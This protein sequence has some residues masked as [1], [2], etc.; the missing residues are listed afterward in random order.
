[1]TEYVSS[2]LLRG[3]IYEPGKRES[4]QE[5]RR[6]TPIYDGTP[7]MFEEYRFRVEGKLRAVS[8]AA[9]ENVDFKHAELAGQLFDGLEAPRT[10]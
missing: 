8:Q 2:R 10:S 6:G 9:E 7:D 3:L 5:K 4:L 1:M